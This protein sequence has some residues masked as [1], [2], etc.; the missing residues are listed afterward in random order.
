MDERRDLCT[1]D[2]ALTDEDRRRIIA[3]IHSLLFW[4]GESIPQD[5]RLDDRTVPLRDAVYNYII[6]ADRTREEQ[7]DA[8]V[9][10]EMLDLEIKK[11]EEEIRRGDVTR[12]Q[13]CELMNEARALLRAVDELRNATGD[14]AGLMRHDLMKR[15]EDAQRW[16][17]FVDQVHGP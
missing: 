1:S 5:V 3:R 7:E 17:H 14:E 15:V 16:K 13:A 11:M 9:L 12:A 2:K 10:A 6:K 4:V 8:E